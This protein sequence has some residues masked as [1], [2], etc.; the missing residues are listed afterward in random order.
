MSL[1][2]IIDNLIAICLSSVGYCV[3]H[4]SCSKS[5]NIFLVSTFLQTLEQM[6][7][8]FQPWVLC[9]VE[10]FILWAQNVTLHANSYN[11]ITFA[12]TLLLF[13]LSPALLLFRIFHRHE[14]SEV[15]QVEVIFCM[16][17]H[18]YSNNILTIALTDCMHK[19]KHTLTIASTT[20]YC[21]PITTTPCCLTSQRASHG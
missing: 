18:K 15:S 10:S 1:S 4:L 3:L 12:V 19:V 21:V 7:H 14:F 9:P 20:L 6:H 16:I 11:G 17:L 8:N 13:S 2:A 5:S